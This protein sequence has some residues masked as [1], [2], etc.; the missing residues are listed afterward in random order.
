M[1]N[2]NVSYN[3]YFIYRMIYTKRIVFTLTDVFVIRFDHCKSKEIFTNKF[4]VFF[5]NS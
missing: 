3:I 2:G 1:F 5:K 4:N